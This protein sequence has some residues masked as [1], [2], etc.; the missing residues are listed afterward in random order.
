MV[1]DRHV[2]GESNSAEAELGAPVGEVGAP[3]GTAGVSVC[4]HLSTAERE[5]ARAFVFVRVC[6]CACVTYL[7]STD[8]VDATD[9]KMDPLATS[10][11]L[12]SPAV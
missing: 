11:D 2:V 10:V 3:A 4:S 5:C 6:V 12:S 8:S 9:S 1:I 7:F